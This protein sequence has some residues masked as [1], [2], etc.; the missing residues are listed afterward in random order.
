M[1][2]NMA[3]LGREHNLRVRRMFQNWSHIL[4][5]LPPLWRGQHLTCSEIYENVQAN[6]GKRSEIIAMLLPLRRE[7]HFRRHPKLSKLIENARKCLKCRHGSGRSNMFEGFGNVQIHNK[8]FGY[9]LG[10]EIRGG[11]SS[12]ILQTSKSVWPKAYSNEQN[13]NGPTKAPWH[14]QIK[15][16]SQGCS[17]HPCS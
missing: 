14:T 15:D 7:Q 5:M 11:A 2:E 9:C 6:T 17:K 12:T 8:W 16:W 1:L 13:E 4:G 3:P 10:V